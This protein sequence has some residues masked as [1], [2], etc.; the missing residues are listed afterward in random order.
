MKLCDKASDSKAPEFHP[1]DQD[2]SYWGLKDPNGNGRC[3][4]S[5]LMD[6]TLGRTVDYIQVHVYACNPDYTSCTAG[7]WS[8]KHDNPYA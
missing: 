1:W 2:G 8:V 6:Y 5:S 3:V 4:T 7:E